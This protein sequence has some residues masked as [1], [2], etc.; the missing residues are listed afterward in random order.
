MFEI[1]DVAHLTRNE[2]KLVD[3]NNVQICVFVV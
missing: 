3:K 1:Q 2:N